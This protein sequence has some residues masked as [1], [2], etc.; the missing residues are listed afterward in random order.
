[1]SQHESHST[2]AIEQASIAATDDGQVGEQPA[3]GLVATNDV[4]V[5]ENVI[6]ATEHG[7]EAIVCETPASDPAIGRMARKLGA[8]VF[9][10]NAADP[11]RNECQE[12]LRAIA[13]VNDALGI[14]LPPHGGARVDVDRSLAQ[15][16]GEFVIPTVTKK[17]KT[18]PEVLVAIPS[19]NEEAAIGDVVRGALPHADEVL[20]IDDGST[21][22]TVEIA[23][24]AGATVIEHERNKGYGG[25]LNTAFAEAADRNAEHLVILDGDGQHDPSDIPALVAVQ[26][27][28]DV[29]I[30]IGSRFAE[31]AETKMPLYRR[32]GVEVVNVLT[33]FSMGVVRPR[34]WV[35]DTQS[36]FRVYDAEAIESLNEDDSIGDGM[37]ASTDI[38]HHGHHHSYEMTEVGTTINYDVEDASTHSPVSHGINLVRNILQ[39][40]EHER[41]VTVLGVPGFL[42]SFVGLGLGYWTFS[43]YISTGVFPLGLA[44]SSTFFALAGIFAC[45][46]AII[47]HSLN[48]HM[49]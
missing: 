13:D 7:L 35:D 14:I 25:A 34:S 46:T 6:E 47:L 15:A 18:E 44:V 38:L 9:E 12:V 45:F 37:S 8:V 24:E 27:E 2:E 22:D 28:E 30:V 33:N 10:M 21:D 16:D 3:I 11:T 5:V 42:S 19:Y 29:E 31:G 26:T 39:T 49:N 17:G 36:G 48:T 32:F 41:P 40:V 20:V 4:T 43:N 23:S 1:M